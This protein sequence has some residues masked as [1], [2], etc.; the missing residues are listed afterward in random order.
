MR[1]IALVASACLLAMFTWQVEAATVV[2]MTDAAVQGGLSPYN[3]VTT[4][5]AASTTVCG[6][7]VR[8]GFTGTRNVALEVDTSRI[9]LPDASRFPILAWT[10][11]S[12]PENSHQLRAG[13]TSITLCADVADPDIDLFVK[14]MCPWINRYEGDPPP[15]AVTI[16]GFRI[17]D[18]GASVVAEQP[19]G[20]WLSIGDSITSG[21][22]AAYAAAEGRPPKADWARSDDARASYAWLLAKHFG[23]RDARLAYGGYNWTGGLANV[24]T[25]VTL[26]DQKTST[27]SRLAGDSLEPPPAI[28][29]VNL[30]TNGRPAVEDVAASL[31]ALRKRVGPRATMIVL[32]P[33]NGAARAEVTAGFAAYEQ[34]VGDGRARLIDLGRFPFETA[35]RVHPTAAGHR[36][37]FEHL[38]PKISPILVAAAKG[39]VSHRPAPSQSP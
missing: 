39:E 7:F 17:D 3:W 36:T 4:A 31:M 18:G 6:A 5:D 13:E 32:V 20:I 9:D 10:I 12:G 14:G 19:A 8:V 1:E 25:L 34:A 30:G 33:F 22:A 23:F 38:M 16:T 37:I 21:D 26:I 27:T 11:N 35:D 24:P 2:P 15:N 28:V 29:S